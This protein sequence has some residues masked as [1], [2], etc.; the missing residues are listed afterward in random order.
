[1]KRLSWLSNATAFGKV[2][3]ALTA[4]PPSPENPELPFPATVDI[5]PTEGLAKTVS[6]ATPITK[7]PR[8]RLQTTSRA[9]IG[10]CAARCIET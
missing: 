7:A 3:L 1:M 5:S 8:T 6:P 10:A 9:Q 4:G 2:M